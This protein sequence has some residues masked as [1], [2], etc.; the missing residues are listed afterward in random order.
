MAKA[1]TASAPAVQTPAKAPKTVTVACKFPTGVVLQLCRKHTYLE[2]SQSGTRE[3]TRWDKV[4]PTVTVRGPATPAGPAPRGFPAPPEIAGGYAL[5]PNVDADFFA[6]WMKQNEQNPLVLNKMIFAHASHGH[7]IGE[8]RDLKDS[9]SGFEPLVPDTDPRMPR[10][11]GAGVTGIQTADEMANRQ[12]LPE[13]SA[14][15]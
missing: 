2:E 8:A 4:G 15:A 14:T 3:R 7:A 5:T 10:P 12:P 11:I 9:R 1:A 13:T 6:E